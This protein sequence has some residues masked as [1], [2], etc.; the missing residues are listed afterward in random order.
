V[1]DILIGQLV[2]RRRS[3]D[4][5]HAE[6]SAGDGERAGDVVAVADVCQLAAFYESVFGH[7]PIAEINA[8]WFQYIMHPSFRS[9]ESRSS[10]SPA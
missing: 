10:G 8:A 6:S 5:A 4:E 1:I 9:E 7:V 3:E 2:P